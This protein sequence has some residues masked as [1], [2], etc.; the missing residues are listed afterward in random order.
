VPSRKPL[1][2]VSFG[3]HLTAPRRIGDSVRALVGKPVAWCLLVG[4]LAS[5]PLVW[6]LRARLPPLPPILGAVA[7]FE[8]ADTGGRRFGSKDLAGR[9]WIATFVDTRCGAPCTSVTR[10][11]ARIQARTRQLEPALHLV[12]FSA[13]PARDGP[14]RVAA[15][16][17]EHRASPRMWTFL[18]GPEAELREL[19]NE[20][21]EPRSAG[22]GRRR[23]DAL[24]GTAIVLVD[25]AARVRG[26][27]DP[28]LP[29]V[30]DRVVR[31]A[32][33]LV[34]APAPR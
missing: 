12:T 34:N 5:W 18:T 26:R 10:Q 20:A 15:L 9:V 1:L 25:G 23:D 30:V 27:Y 28:G 29:D 8:L 16:A 22:E 14:E 24:Q 11:V 6:S 33:L 19:A 17:R 31:D 21:L 7:E 4:T 32:A 3:P 2:A 13:A